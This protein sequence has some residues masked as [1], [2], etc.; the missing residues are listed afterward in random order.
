M[1][2]LVTGATGFTGG[3]LARTLIRDGHSVKALVR[4][5][6]SAN[7]ELAQAGIELVEGQLTR[8]EDVKRAAQGCDQIYHIAA[9]FRTAG[10]PDSHYRDVNVGGTLNVLKAAQELGC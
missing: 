5:G 6:S 8:A 10:H 4:P 9:V 2:C 1:K 7:K 3:H